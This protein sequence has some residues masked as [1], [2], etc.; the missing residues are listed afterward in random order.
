MAKIKFTIGCDPEIMLAGPNGLV[1]AIPFYKGTKD[2]PEKVDGGIVSHDNVNVEFGS[3]PASSKEE[4]IRNTKAVIG[5]VIEMAPANHS[6][7]V[8][9]SAEF[10]DEQLQDEEARKF[11]C[12]PDFD[13]YAV[14]INNAPDIRKSPNLRSCGGHIHVGSQFLTEDL[15]D[16]IGFTKAMDIFLGIPAVLLDKDP[17]SAHRRNLY[18]KAG[19]HRPKPYGVEYRTLSNFW[20]SRPRLTSLMYDLTE[21]ALDAY[22]DKHTHGIDENGIKNAI[23]NGDKALAANILTGFIRKL[24]KPDVYKEIMACK[25]LV[26]KADLKE[27]CE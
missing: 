21:A 18:G 4:W 11:G 7:V 9:A 24:V 26:H 6:L 25:K 1:S 3:N 13:A 14:A 10:P 23:N 17:S 27:W 19:C 20:V 5:K 22:T 16:V 12:D 8:Q 15:M 2:K